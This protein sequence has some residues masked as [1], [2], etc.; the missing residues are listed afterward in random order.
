[1]L[2]AQLLAIITAALEFAF[3]FFDLFDGTIG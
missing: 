3:S 1:M 2:L